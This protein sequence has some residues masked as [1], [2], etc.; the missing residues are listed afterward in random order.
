MPARTRSEHLERLVRTWLGLGADVPAP[1]LPAA[2]ARRLLRD[3]ERERPARDQWGNWEFGLCEAFVDGTLWEPEVDQWLATQDSGAPRWPGGA[4]FAVCL[5]H[6]VDIVAAGYSA[7]QAL[8]LVRA[9]ATASP[10]QRDVLGRAVRA[11]G[12]SSALL[13]QRGGRA[14]DA[15]PVLQRCTT[16]ERDAGVR[17]S[18]FVPVHAGHATNP[19]DVCVYALDDRCTWGGRETTVAAVLRELVAE[20]FDIGLHGSYASATDGERLRDE[21]ERLADAL[22]TDVT[23]SRQHWLHWE[24]TGTPARQEAAGLRADS[25]LGFNRN[26]GF[27]AGTSLPFRWWDAEAGRPLDLIQL[28]LVVQEAAL[29]AANALELDRAGAI[30]VWERLL[31]RVSDTGGVATLLVH[32]HALA[33][34]IVEALYREAVAEAVRAGAW[35]ATLAQI[36]AHW[37]AREARLGLAA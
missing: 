33:D 21:C 26:V 7:R 19:Y 10:G 32:P 31:E 36:D 12:A 17:G 11:A 28:P 15:G 35:V 14:P 5:T 25:T 30:A 37:R 20:G 34:P 9:R 22:G 13:W 4:P 27:R 3:E 2:L 6:D 29:T 8:R 23:T 18:Y 1:E 24:I 16:V